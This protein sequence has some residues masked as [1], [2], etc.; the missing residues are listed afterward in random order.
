MSLS[1]F[2]FLSLHATFFAF[3]LLPL[4]KTPKQLSIV[5]LLDIYVC[6]SLFIYTT[7]ILRFIKI[8]DLIP[9]L[10]CLHCAALRVNYKISSL[11]ILII[12]THTGIIVLAQRS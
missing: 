8:L 3:S 1:R 10:H 5:L 4:L 6:I 9:P 11:F 2:S 12:C 7:R